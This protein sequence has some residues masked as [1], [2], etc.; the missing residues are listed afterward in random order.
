MR[1]R[2]GGKSGKKVEGG[3][4]KQ[5]L[6][7][8]P[9]AWKKVILV[10]FGLGLLIGAVY[11]VM[12]T[13]YSG[14]KHSEDDSNLKREE[15]GRETEGVDSGISCEQLMQEAKSIVDNRP[16][17]EWENALDL[18]ATC[19]L[20]EPDN[21]APQ[22]NLAVTLMQMNRIDEALHFVDEAL[23]RDPNNVEFLKTGGVFLS[24][25]GY[26]PEAVKCLEWYLEV[27]LRVPSWEQLLASISIQREDEWM[28]LYDA[29]DDVVHVFEVLLHSYLQDQHLIKAGYLYKIIIGLKGPQNDQD[30][31]LAY[32][33]FSF[34]LGDLITGMKYLRMYTEY[35][36]VAQGYGNEV[37][38]YEVVTAHSL[39]LFTSGLDSH[40]TS[41]TKNL[42]MAGEVVWEELVYNCELTEDNKF[43]FT[44]LVKQSD[45]R[46]VLVKCILSQNIIDV[47]V[48]EGAVVYAENIFGWTPLL[49]A[50]SLGSKE[51]VDQLTKR[52]ADP[53]ART[54]LALSALH[55]AAIKGSY[56][57]VQLLLLAGLK[58]TTA[59]YFNR[60]VL[61]IACLHGWSAHG[62]AE[63]LSIGNLPPQ[64]PYKPVHT[65]PLKQTFHGGWLG[66][67]VAL[68]DELTQ[69][70]CD[71]DVLITPDVQTFL[72][73]YLTLQRPVL[74]RNAT[75]NHQMKTLFQLWQRNK[76]EQEYGSLTVNE[77][78]IP[79]AEFAGSGNQ[80]TIRTYLSKMKQL[81]HESKEQGKI[82]GTT[83]PMY[84]Y[85]SVPMDSPLLRDLKLPEILNPDLTHISTA[86][87][88]FY[89]GPAISGLPPHYHRSTWDLLIYGHNR[90]FLFPPNKAF[91]SKQHVWG[92]WEGMYR[93]DP[94]ALECV[95]HSGDVVFVP[96]MW[97]H[98]VI[99]L[100]ES[101]GVASQFT[102]GASEFSI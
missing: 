18:L 40:I 71:L 36:Y 51:V 3:G 57:I 20:Q 75:N 38:G 62:M 65:P 5:K 8:P 44:D 4:G 54:V 79:H 25:M 41:I 15:D 68:P 37:Q 84:V 67:G 90:W 92:W 13:R 70:R 56:D 82:G 28:F 16:P 14:P 55:I 49:H 81:H 23:S 50:T 47:L 94:T 33:Y 2:Q 17:G 63:A 86:K 100:R 45:V 42:L 89:V 99:S 74:I 88:F 60:T 26:Y 97:G 6:E 80:T 91:Y 78:E 66:S 24:Q 30:L 77:Y 85:Q 53:L 46:Q 61:Q 35:Q 27:S 98:A 73:D 21:A 64:C 34:G 12:P 9:S 52:K 72:Y 31:L 11:L 1:H 32:S 10:I 48:D 96:D 69:E 7:T 101:I 43:N 87:T 59:D 76:F 22:W 93:G 39:R 102:H 29:G 58:P 83:P 95:Q 19:A